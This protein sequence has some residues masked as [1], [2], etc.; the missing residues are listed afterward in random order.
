MSRAD[1][2]N[3]ANSRNVLR[4]SFASYRTF[5]SLDKITFYRETSAPKL[6]LRDTHER[7]QR[8]FTFQSII[9]SINAATSDTSRLTFDLFRNSSGYSRKVAE[10]PARISRF[11]EGSLTSLSA[12]KFFAHRALRPQV[13]SPS[14]R[15]IA[16]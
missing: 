10:S 13:L 11:A 12:R 8:N 5:I 4:S 14:Q 7:G 9:L 1:R 6:L 15:T 2:H 16:L 3:L